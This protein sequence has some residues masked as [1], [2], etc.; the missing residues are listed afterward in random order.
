MNRGGH[1]PDAVGGNPG[2]GHPRDD[3]PGRIPES[4][5]DAVLDGSVDERTRREIARALRHD[6]SRREDVVRTLRAIDAMRSPIDCP[7]FSAPVLASLDRRHRFV[8]ARVRRSLRQTRLGLAAAAMVALVGAA[9]AQRAMPRLATI[10]TPATPVTDMASAV[11]ADTARAADDVIEGV[12]DSA[13][14]VRAALPTPRSLAD[15]LTVPGRSYRVS[16]DSVARQSPPEPVLR[17]FAVAGG[18]FVFVQSPPGV[19][20]DTDRA[21]IVSLTPFA[22]QSARSKTPDTDDLP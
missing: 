1:D 16:V 18:R 15:S 10:G 3:A 12:R 22:D 2:R 14:V 19:H 20:A 8:S 13:V 4:L 9:V 11:C 6:P 21:G 5:I 17:V 7:D